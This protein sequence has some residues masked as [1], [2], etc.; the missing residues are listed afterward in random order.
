MEGRGKEGDGPSPL[1]QIPRSVLKSSDNQQRLRILFYDD[2]VV[3]LSRHF[4]ECRLSNAK[5]C[6][7]TRNVQQ[8]QRQQMPDIEAASSPSSRVVLLR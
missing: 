3:G 4:V 6:E 5:C 1:T 2:A 8:P 7:R